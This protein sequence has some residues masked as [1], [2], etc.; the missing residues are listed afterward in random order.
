[1]SMTNIQV[2]RTWQPNRLQN[3]RYWTGTG[4]TLNSDGSVT[5]AAGGVIQ[6]S[7]VFQALDSAAYRL[8]HIEYAGTVTEASNIANKQAVEFIMNMKYYDD[9]G[10]VCF[11]HYTMPITK[12]SSTQ[13]SEG[14]YV[15]DKLVACTEVAS[16]YIT[17]IIQNN[18]T[19]AIT[20]KAISLRQSMDMQAS[21]LADALSYQSR[22]KSVVKY[23]NGFDLYYY[24]Y[25]DPVVLTRSEDAQG[26][27]NGVYVGP[28]N[29]QFIP[30]D[31]RDFNR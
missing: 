9:N 12:E 25:D 18:T 8:L 7:L 28:N 26:H 30:C 31:V 29:E 5:I 17:A 14:N 19:S 16:Q 20:I 27:F 1:M 23:L 11:E 2:N 13:I 6:N 21:Q 4:M 22:L 3:L 15:V 24:G 10:D